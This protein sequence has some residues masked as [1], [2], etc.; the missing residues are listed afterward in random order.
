MVRLLFFHRC[1]KT[2]PKK[3]SFN[4]PE[5]NPYDVLIILLEVV[6]LL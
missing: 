2:F 4:H 5:I 6:C 3:H 1:P